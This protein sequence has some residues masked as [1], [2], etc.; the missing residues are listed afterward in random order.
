MSTL[1]SWALAA[2]VLAAALA[3]PSSARACGG[4]FASG[5]EVS[6]DQTILVSYRSGLETYVMRPHFCG[7]AKD[8]GVILPIPTALVGAPELAD[9]AL[10][11]DLAAHTAPEVVEVCKSNK[12][13]IG[14]G[15]AKEAGSDGR[16]FADAGAPPVNVVDRGRVG[17]FEYVLLQATNSAAFTDWL[18]QNGFP[19]STSE[20]LYDGYVQK[21]WYFVAF[22]VAASADAPPAGMKL[23]GDLGPIQLSFNSAELV[24][25]ARIAE[26]NLADA[27][28]WRVAIAAASGMDLAPT[29]TYSPK[30][31]FRGAVEPAQMT[32]TPKLAGFV[33]EGERLSVIDV[34]FPYQGPLADL[35][36]VASATSDDYRTR[37]YVEKDCGGGCV[38][39]GVGAS[40]F[41]AAIALAG[42][43]AGLKRSRRR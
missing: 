29:A 35:T 40:G 21:Q 15:A 43:L 20:S 25:P 14:C 32:A 38:A 31:Y 26:V 11:D 5:I 22:K 39:G 27:P 17:S 13:A 33:R 16:A 19:H 12:V 10:Y 6:P 41:V 8:F 34:R 23:C 30:L 7:L 4:F 2:A 18:G 28:I 42:V 3:A 24:I 1:R 9:D 37:K 36:F